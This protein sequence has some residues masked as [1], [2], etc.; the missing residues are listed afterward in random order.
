MQKW[1]YLLALCAGLVVGASGALLWGAHR[2]RMR[3]DEMARASCK[4]EILD[5]Y[6]PLKLI[7][8][9]QTDKAILFLDM[10]LGHAVA[11]AEKHWP[12]L[13]TPASEDDVLATA[14]AL[15]EE[16]SRSAAAADT[17]TVENTGEGKVEP[18]EHPDPDA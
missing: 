14:K 17:N 4:T 16:R 1:G 5:A 7:N 2:T 3:V 13:A 18:S 9:G 11:R 6:V 8:E 12:T 15:L 10:A